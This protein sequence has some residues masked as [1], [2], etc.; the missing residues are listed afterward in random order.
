[1]FIGGG[2]WRG[3][4]NWRGENFWTTSTEIPQ[5]Y[6]LS[7]PEKCIK[8]NLLSADNSP[9]VGSSRYSAEQNLNKRFGSI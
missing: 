6:I 8:T 9:A 5:L 4:L 2:A 3:K 7:F 1:M